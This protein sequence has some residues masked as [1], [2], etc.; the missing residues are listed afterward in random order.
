MTTGPPCPLRL[1]DCATLLEAQRALAR[2]FATAGLETPDV[3][4]RFLVQKISGCD[5]A[6]LLGEPGTQLIPSVRA[7]LEEAARRRLQHEPVSRILGEREFYGRMFAITPDV[8]DPRPET[9]TLVE[10]ALAAARKL[11]PGR[12]P[13]IADAGT[14]SG[15]LIVTL[16][17]ELADATGVAT[18]ISPAALAVARDNA[19]RH[20]VEARVEFVHTSCLKGVAGPF[21]LIVSNPPYI[22]GTEI[23]GLPREV[24]EFDPL[25]A[26]DGGPDGLDVYR[27]I[28]SDI[29]SLRLNCW[30]GLEIGA[31]QA[32]RVSEIFRVTFPLLPAGS[33]SYV[34][35]LG[36]H[37]RCVAVEIHC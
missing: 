18:D 20:G 17:A 13:R 1:E 34:R 8:L 25:L 32:D 31:G 2:G 28:T 36:G 14:G 7:R 5:A 11:P 35:D 21:D 4:A 16:L 3:D 22:A 26:L 29:K 15:A 37:V 9:E 30:V 33:I 24:R 12:P 19:A 6:R 10:A 23:V 27:E